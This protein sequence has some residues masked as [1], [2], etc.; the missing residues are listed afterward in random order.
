MPSN[1]PSH[2]D[3]LALRVNALL[4]VAMIMLCAYQ[5]WFFPL[6]V[7]PSG[8]A[9]AWSLVPGVLATT[10]FWAV[11]HEAIHGRLF[12]DRR[13]NLMTGRVLS[14]LFGAPFRILRFGHLLHHRLYAASSEALWPDDLNVSG[15]SLARPAHYLQVLIGVYALEVATTVVALL[16]VAML[17]MILGKLAG[18]REGARA[19]LAVLIERQLLWRG[20]VRANRFDGLLILATWASG[21]AL[22]GEHGWVL[23]IALVLRGLL[24]SYFD[25]IYHFSR[26]AGSDRQTYNLHVPYWLSTLLLHANYHAVH[27]RRPGLPWHALPDA[28]ERDGDD[29]QHS[30]LRACIDQALGPLPA[31]AA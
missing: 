9:W 8:V 4:A 24:V 31:K 18:G 22:Y 28:F 15:R 30:L 3:L 10:T 11:I 13:T 7:L 19:R 26:Q 21:L 20:A 23:L 14:I 16:P 6:L 5:F 12:A 2:R 17:R 27:H 25:N 1:S 29:M